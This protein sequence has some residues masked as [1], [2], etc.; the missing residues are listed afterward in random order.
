MS[1]AVGDIQTAMESTMATV[2]G[3][4]Y[5]ELDYKHDLPKNDFRN[6][7]KRYGVVP[8]GGLQVEGSIKVYTVDQVFEM[9]LTH[10]TIDR[11]T[12]ED[13]SAKEFLLFEKT[14]AILKEMIQSKLGIPSLVMNVSNLDLADPEFLEP[15]NIV[16][17][18]TRLTVK[19]ALPLTV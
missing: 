15:D 3:A 11:D 6:S 7:D 1:T 4:T 19:Y 14:H 17:Q 8:L 10:G 12:D 18:R 9:V 2:L 16:V 13:R 5:F